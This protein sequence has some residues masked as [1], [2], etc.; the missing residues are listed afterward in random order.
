MVAGIEHVYTGVREDFLSY[1][2]ALEVAFESVVQHACKA[3][4]EHF[5]EPRSIAEVMQL[6]PDEREQWLKAAQDKIQSL[7]ENSTFELAR[8]PPGRKAIGSR[9][10]FRVK[11]NADGS[12]E[13]YKGRLV[14]KGFSQRPGFDYNETFAPTPKWASIRAIL[15]LAAL[16]DLEL[17]SVDISSA[18][19]NGEL[20]EGT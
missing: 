13:R 15:A 8:L 18:Y 12:I 10:V 11:R 5:G 20:K 1:D 4:Q 2:D 6:A 16:E 19:L 9:W 7:V 3:N 17:E 14:A